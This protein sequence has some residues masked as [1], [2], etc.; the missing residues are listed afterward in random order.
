MAVYQ[1]VGL[2]FCG[3]SPM[4]VISFLNLYASP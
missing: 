1:F 4:A 3:R 2:M